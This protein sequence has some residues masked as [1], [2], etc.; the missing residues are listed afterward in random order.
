NLSGLHLFKTDSFISV[1]D[2]LIMIVICGFLLIGHMDNHTFDIRWF[3]YAQT[4]A[5]LIT[6]FLTLMIVIDKASLKKLTWKLSFFLIIL[7]NS[8]P[9][10]VLVLLMTF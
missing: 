8:Y 2:R 3:V 7:K 4:A 1:V 10:A 5:Y 6:A 9:Y